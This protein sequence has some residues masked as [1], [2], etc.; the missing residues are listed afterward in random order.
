MII[1][2]KN[3]KIEVPV[4]KVSFFGKFS[5]LMFRGKNISNLLFDF[6]KNSILAIHSYFVFFDFLAV[7]LDADNNVLET[8]IVKP[9]RIS[10]CPKMPFM[11]LVEIP[12]NEKNI[13]IIEF[14]VGK[15]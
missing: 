9:F 3:K 13:R 1:N 10:I 14:F 8:E 7:W 2:Y 4:K 15:R 5:G 12:F 11:K 6:K